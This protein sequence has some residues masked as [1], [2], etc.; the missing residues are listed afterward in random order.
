M[1]MLSTQMRVLRSL[2]AANSMKLC[3]TQDHHP[4]GM[5]SGLAMQ[6]RGTRGRSWGHEHSSSGGED[7]RV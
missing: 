4:V 5:A 3:L 2:P 7:P 6:D 1:G